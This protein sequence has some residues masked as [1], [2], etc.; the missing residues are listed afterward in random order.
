MRIDELHKFSDGTLN[1]VRNT[2]DDRLKGI[3]MQ[4]LPT[5]IWR[6]GDKD[7]ATAMIQAIDKMLKTRRIMRSLER[8]VSLMLEILSKRFFLKLNLSDHSQSSSPRLD[9]KDLKQTDIDDLEEI[10]L[11]WKGHFA[12]ECRSPKDSRRSGTT[13]PHRRTI[14]I[15]TSTSNA[16]V[17]QCDGTFMSSKPDLVF[18][19]VPT[20]VETDH[21]AFNPFETSILAATPKPTNPKFNSSGKRRNRKTCFVCKSVDHLIKDCDSHAK[22]M[23]QPTHKNYAH[24]SKP[25]FN[26]AVR[27]VSAAMPKINVTRPRYAHQIVTKSKSSIIRHITHSQS[28]KTSNLHPRVTAVQAPVV[29][30]AQGMQG[31]WDNPQYAFKDKGVIDSGCSRHMTGNMSYL[32]EFKELNGGYV[33]FGGNP[34]GGKIFGKGKIKTDSLGKF[35]GKVDE[36]F[37]VGY[38]VNSKAFRVFNSITRIVEETLHNY[39]GDVAFD[40]KEHDFD[41]KKPESE[42]ILSPSSKFEDCSNNI[43]NELNAAS[44][45]VPTVGQ[46]FSNSTNPFSITSP[47]NVAAS[48]TYGKSLFKDASQLPDDSDMLELEDITYSDDE[49]DVG[50]EANFNNLETSITVSHIPTTRNHKDYPVSQ[51]IGDMSSTT[52][53][54]IMIRVIKDQGG[55]SQMFD[56]DFHTCM[57]ACFLSQKE[58]KRVHQA[59]KDPSWIEAIKEELLQFK[60]QKVWILVDLP[61]GKRAISTKWVYRNKKDARGIVIRKR[62]R[63]FTQG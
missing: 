21:L 63:L 29:N 62:V 15:E 36:G 48:L 20:A 25:I 49:N 46:I 60:M 18:H 16:L 14:P 50:A 56:N 6:K 11:R 40:G 34:K 61:H 31:K 4:Y 58:P 22:Q 30:V 37:L 12:R 59:L 39:D 55:L 5:T 19:I 44:S 41:A 10:D 23:A 33:A 32:S 52:E 57:F 24:R 35:E 1:D 3:R 9:N 7:R 47:S 43:S 2:L 13:K 26:T 51:I 27:P 53:T 54:R 17:S 8:K 28:P 45:I 38:L 42:V